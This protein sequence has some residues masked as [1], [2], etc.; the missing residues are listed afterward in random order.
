M[1]LIFL[2]L[3]S[4]SALFSLD[5]LL[6]QEGVCFVGDNSNAVLNNSTYLTTIATSTACTTLDTWHIDYTGLIKYCDYDVNRVTW[7]YHVTQYTFSG[8]QSMAFDTNTHYLNQ[9]TCTVDS[10]PSCVSPDI[11]DSNTSSCVTPVCGIPSGMVAITSLNESMCVGSFTDLQTDGTGQSYGE[12]IWQAC[13]STCYGVKIKDL[14]C[15]DLETYNQRVCNGGSHNVITCNS[16]NGIGK[17][18]FDKSGC[19][20]DVNPCD[21]LYDQVSSRCHQDGFHVV[22][23]PEC[24]HSGMTVTNNSI[25]CVENK[26]DPVVPSDCNEAFFEIY[27]WVTSTCECQQGYGRNNFGNCAIPLDTN[28]TAQQIADKQNKDAQDE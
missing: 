11:W 8:S 28:A 23:Y 27:S 20:P 16:S 25:K 21:T 13:D 7:K 5:T 26:P 14:S 22:G 2:F 15:T 6:H 17:I 1:R 10:V 24:T 12:L 9:S 18:N 19:I 4:Y 3:F